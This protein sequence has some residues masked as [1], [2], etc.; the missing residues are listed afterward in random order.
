[1]LNEWVAIRQFYGSPQTHKS[2]A[3]KTGNHFVPISS[4]MRNAGWLLE[5]GVEDVG[6]LSDAWGWSKRHCFETKPTIPITYLLT[7]CFFSAS[8]KRSSLPLLIPIVLFSPHSQSVLTPR[9]SLCFVSKLCLGHLCVWRDVRV[10]CAGYNLVRGMHVGSPQLKPQI[11]TFLYCFGHILLNGVFLSFGWG[12]LNSTIQGAVVIWRSWL[13]DRQLWIESWT[14]DWLMPTFQI[15][16]LLP[17]SA[18]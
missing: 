16:K 7:Y 6:V 9:G 1:M 11:P 17:I 5:A 3:T 15:F 13:F 8:F 14:E 12:V 18:N 2:R 10:L 4:Q